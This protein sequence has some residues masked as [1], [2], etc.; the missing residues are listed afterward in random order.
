MKFRKI[1]TIE[2]E[3]E[4]SPEGAGEM[5]KTISHIRSLPGVRHLEA[6]LRQVALLKAAANLGI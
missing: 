6:E 3:A 1:M 2:I 5:I 4:D